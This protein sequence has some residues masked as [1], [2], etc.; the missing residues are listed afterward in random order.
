M[1]AAVL[2][3]LALGGWVFSPVAFAPQLSRLSPLAGLQR[4]FGLTGLVELGKAL[5]KFV[6][7]G[8]AAGAVTWWLMRDVVALGSMPIAA[9]MARGS[10][11]LALAFLLMSAA[12]GLIAVVD[13]PYQWWSFRRNL[14]MTRQQVRDEL[15]ESEGRPE[16]KAKVRQLQQRYAR[17][18]MMLDVPRADVVI[19]NPE[20]YSVALKYDASSM[21]APRVLAKGRDLVALEIRRIA[22]EHGV[23]VFEAPPLARALYG[24]TE[25]GREIPSG[26]YVAV[27]QVLSY[28]YQLK[29]AAPAVKARLRRPVPDVGPEFSDA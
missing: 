25:I 26:L 6:V 22:R 27:A 4:I 9:A 16:I 23:P 19:V 10:H 18:R 15:K 2:A 11:I 20:H 21:R 1:I 3:P 13:A 24:S 17:R 8:A 5:L 7:V 28:L 29:S 14:K 12:L